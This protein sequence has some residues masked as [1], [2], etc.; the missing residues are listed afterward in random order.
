M[1][2]PRITPPTNT[3]S[4]RN[5]ASLRTASS[6]RGRF[7]SGIDLLSEELYCEVS[8]ARSSATDRIAKCEDTVEPGISQRSFGRTAVE[9]GERNAANFSLRIRPDRG[10]FAILQEARFERFGCSGGGNAANHR[11]SCGR[12]GVLQS[13]REEFHER[14][15]VHS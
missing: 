2:R 14:G 3:I 4:S 1:S 6:N 11:A 12:K 9:R 13:V 5:G 7:G 8:F 15:S 10:W